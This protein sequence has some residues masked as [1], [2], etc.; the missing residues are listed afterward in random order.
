MTR[1]VGVRN[2]ERCW[3]GSYNEAAPTE[4]TFDCASD[5]DIGAYSVTL[6]GDVADGDV[7]YLI[8]LTGAVLPSGYLA[9][10]FYKAVLISGDEFQLATAD[11]G[12]TIDP[13]AVGSGTC[14]VRKVVP[15]PTKPCIA[16]AYEWEWGYKGFN[17]RQLAYDLLVEV[18]GVGT[19]TS[20]TYTIAQEQ[21]VSFADE[22]V[23]TLPHDG[24]EMDKSA[25]VG[26]LERTIAVTADFAVSST[27]GVVTSTTFTYYPLVTGYNLTY[28]WNFGDG[29]TSTS[30]SPTHNYTVDDKRYTVSLTV[31]NSY[32]YDTRLREE[33]ITI[34]DPPDIVIA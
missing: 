12:S 2:A 19:P 18:D 5:V 28:V 30:E 17:P 3:V 23:A 8:P 1:F 15:L 26:W 25:F 14:R 34:G 33:W 22:I 24:W 9:G 20:K 11:G 7:V 10:T 31:K 27:S 13:V 16:K 6:T 29:G 21:H 32:A 4:S